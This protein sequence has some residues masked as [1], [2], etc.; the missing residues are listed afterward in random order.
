MSQPLA[1]EDMLGLMNEVSRYSERTLASIFERPEC[2]TSSVCLEQLMQDAT[3]NGLLNSYEETGIS[4]WENAHDP[5]ILQ[6]SCK[7][8]YE[9]AIKNAG[10]AYLFHHQSVSYFVF[11]Q[12][13]ITFNTE[14]VPVMSLQG[15]FGLA[16]HSLARFLMGKADQKDNVILQDYFNP[17]SD[18]SFVF[19]SR[20]D[21][22]HLLMPSFEIKKNKQGQL[23]G[24]I[25]FSVLPRKHLHI[26]VLEHGH[27][28][29]EVS[30]FLCKKTKTLPDSSPHSLTVE[31]SVALYA[32]ALQMQWL[33]L[34]SIANG[35]TNKALM[36]T[37]EYAAIRIQG[38][39]TIEHHP[40]VQ[41][42]LSQIISAV[43]CGRSL[44]NSIC[45]QTLSVDSLSSVAQ[46]RSQL[47][48]QFCKASNNAVQVFGGMGYMQDVGVEK[49]VRDN[50]QL[51]LM[52]GTPTELMLFIAE[53]ECAK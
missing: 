32:I 27:G 11:K 39:K 41:Q 14:D 45:S 33:G 17:Q 13:G 50:N 30:V 21:W 42:M 40:A 19:H 16:R 52:N 2:L 31:I 46:I 3:N 53:L 35:V 10:L 1:N 38:G 24:S 47:H 34:M 37:K 51:K 43:G 22:T 5:L 7:A 36:K 20:H 4:L 48:P 9:I 44:I 29:N 26:E 15:H 6:F 8:L 23:K 18:Q 25:Q 49:I 28:L 12:L